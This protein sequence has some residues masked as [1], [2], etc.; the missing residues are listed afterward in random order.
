[1]FHERF[2]LVDVAAYPVT[3]NPVGGAGGVTFDVA[4]VALVIAPNTL[5]TPIVVGVVPELG[6]CCEFAVTLVA[7]TIPFE[8]ILNVEVVLLPARVG[9]VHVTFITVPSSCPP[10]AV[11]VGGRSR[12]VTA[13]LVFCAAAFDPIDA[14]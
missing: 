2:T 4:L 8:M 14:T 3:S 11:I 6:I 12:T 7:T 1:M 5:L 10:S 9:V 13:A